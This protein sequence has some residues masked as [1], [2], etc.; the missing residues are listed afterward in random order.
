[1]SQPISNFSNELIP[2]AAT[3]QFVTP[4]ERL[5]R[6]HKVAY[7]TIQFEGGNG[8]W[9]SLRCT[10]LNDFFHS[11]LARARLENRT[12]TRAISSQELYRLAYQ[13]APT[14]KHTAVVDFISALK[15]AHQYDISPS[16]LSESTIY[17]GTSTQLLSDW[18]QRLQ[19][20]MPTNLISEEL[21]PDYLVALQIHPERH[22][23]LDHIEQLSNPQ[24]RYLEFCGCA[25]AEQQIQINFRFSPACTKLKKAGIHETLTE[26]S[27][28]EYRPKAHISPIQGYS[29][30]REE[31]KAAANWAYET[32]QHNHQAQI[33]I[34]VPNLAANYELVQHHC[35]AFLDSKNGSLTTTFD[36]SSG[37]ALGR[38]PA[39]LDAKHFL[40]M[41]LS[42]TTQS[43][44]I[45]LSNSK[46]FKLQEL[47][48]LAQNWPSEIGESISLESI[49]AHAPSEQLLK[50]RHIVQSWLI[51]LT[52]VEKDSQDEELAHNMLDG[53]CPET[54][55]HVLPSNLKVH[56]SNWLDLFAQLLDS[57]QWPNLT[58]AASV[59]FQQCQALQAALED[60]RVTS[61]VEHEYSQTLPGEDELDSYSY[62]I[63]YHQIIHYID[64]ALMQIVSSAQ[65]TRS[66]INVL[67]T[68]ETTGLQFSH[69]WVCGLDANSFPGA[70][71]GNPFIPVA[72]ARA[73]HVPRTT[74]ADERIFSQT[75]LTQWL[76]CTDHLYL[77][78]TNQINDTPCSPSTLVVNYYANLQNSQ[79]AS[80]ASGALAAETTLPDSQQELLHPDIAAISAILSNR[81]AEENAGSSS[82]NGSVNLLPLDL[83]A[84]DVSANE[85]T[86]IDVPRIEYYQDSYG[87]SFD[88]LHLPGG[89]GLLGDQAQ[90]AFRAYATYR[91]GL[92]TQRQNPDFPDAAERGSLLHH[93][94][95][96]ILKRF[97][98][99]QTLSQLDTSILSS[100]I[101]AELNSLKRKLPIEFVQYELERILNLIEGWLAIES[102]RGEFNAIHLEQSLRLQIG[103]HTLEVRID[104]ID[105]VAG[106][107]VVI[108]YKS[109]KANLSGINTQPIA[110]VQLPMYSLLEEKISG[111]FYTIVKE[112]DF[113]MLGVT[114]P[115]SVLGDDYFPQ[116]TSKRN[117]KIVD[118]WTALRQRWQE[119]LQKL[120]DDFVEGYAAV[121]PT[122]DACTFC[123]FSSLCRINAQKNRYP[124]TLEIS[125]VKPKHIADDQNV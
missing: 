123:N 87:T 111:V 56:P 102:N 48:A 46:F 2:Y 44:L 80:G 14:G 1:M 58:N 72:L 50:V 67:G 41:C 16:S 25:D 109:G 52:L 30:L 35:A 100:F 119:Q 5:A 112:D 115:A 96:R 36:I 64:N 29:H 75:L 70:R 105:E 17:R 38:N 108:D 23:L 19:S 98:Q 27:E 65:R 117:A 62:T 31:I 11:E 53:Q 120:V 113:R 61:Q 73:H 60:L 32:K 118:D 85:A 79:S 90:C 15:T 114:D 77:S 68:L 9:Q 76:Y 43:N 40:E 92:T 55:N 39:W 93:I 10:S 24:Q 13:T 91:L 107:L 78:Y 89:T 94:L 26:I 116:H 81:P 99:R 8:A 28:L 103:R 6:A 57:V 95:F 84:N 110:A 83:S 125:K 4:N 66:D 45:H 21:I 63:S 74:Q 3:H 34:V 37:L 12:Q 104:R 122:T 86:P 97:P 82:T 33:G 124:D 51:E 22:L 59:Q 49:A 88:E 42:E 54:A 69:L 71:S 20:M 7:D 106:Q 121:N 18:V 101:K 47:F